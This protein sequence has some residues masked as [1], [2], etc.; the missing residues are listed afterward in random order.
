MIV[1]RA[2]RIA[3]WRWRPALGAVGFLPA[4]VLAAAFWV[5]LPRPLFHSPYS[6][7]LLDRDGRLLG[8]TIASDGQWRFPADAAVPGKLAR[9][10]IAYEDKRFAVHPGVD[11]LAVGR[12]ILANVRGR[13][14]VS[15]ASTLTMQVIRLSRPGR[16]RSIGEK[17]VEMV[18]A[19]RLSLSATKEEVLRLFAAN[20]PFGGNVVGF[21]AAAWRWF[22]REPRA[23]SWAECAMLAVLPNSPGLVYP[24]SNR[25][26]LLAKR[27]RLLAILA[28]HGEIDR[29]TLA[30]AEEEPLPPE[31]YPLPQLAPHLLARAI[32]EGHAGRLRTTLERDLQVRATEIME[33]RAAGW[34]EAGVESAAA[35]VVDV[36]T[37]SV[38]AYVGNVA[39]GEGT[40]VDVVTA[41]R[42]TGSLLKPFLYAA[43]LDAGELLPDQLVT[44]IPTRIG[45]F[46][47]ENNTRT[48]EGA[49]PASAALARS[50]NVPMVRL[51]RGFGVE[52][53]RGLLTSLGMTTLFRPARDYGLTL[54]IGGAEGTLWELTGMYAGL[55]RCARG[56]GAGGG[57]GAPAFFPPRYLGDAP[58]PSFAPGAG[59]TIGAGASWLA[60]R[61]LLEVARPGEEGAW[62]EF[63]G[64][65]KIA[66]KTG[67]SEGYRDA[68]AI[69][70]T[71]GTAV[72]VWVGNASGASR[73]ELKGSTFAAP[74]LFEL[75]DAVGGLAAWFAEPDSG[76]VEVQTC[77]RSGL[78][79][80]PWCAET[81][82]SLAPPAALTADLTC[83]YCRQVHLEPTGRMRASTRT[84]P[85]AALGSA[86]WFV[87]P[88]AMEWYYRRSHC[89]YR[90]LPPLAPGEAPEERSSPSFAMLYPE[91]GST[92][93]VPIELDGT[94]GRTVLR[95]AHR[96]PRATIFWYLDGAYLGETT[97]LHDMEV[98]PG[99]GQHLLTLVD[100]TGEEIARTFTCL[101]KD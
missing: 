43:M 76:L 79:A 96:N 15:G 51:L 33:R 93:Y 19:L 8:A 82:I 91:Q 52:R 14:V 90:P 58:P 84:Q 98:R 70:V 9:A 60:L 71:P 34:R 6:T 29:D 87:L 47:P 65:R 24:G 101:S 40:D 68:W 28:T 27:N 57:A 10:F 55:A 18:L 17:L 50:L 75:F 88:P 99:A 69:G 31:P 85:M 7:V 56:I 72:G 36:A 44:D 61:A 32:S 67:T 41:P 64:S 2:G 97:E 81:V 49:V 16:P 42:S 20:A 11:P 12:A 59:A 39:S 78:R 73:P 86:S 95:A 54:I 77:A 94:P 21:E 3:P 1:P 45:G 13:E 100:E 63:L 38:R 62:R 35:L 80:G 26:E 4:L 83:R 37:G 22:G 5:S 46:I 53:F 23:L 92:I 89:D 66:W 48:Y 74:A 25:A 30:L